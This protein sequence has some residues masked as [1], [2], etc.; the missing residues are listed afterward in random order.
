VIRF[1]LDTNICIYIIKKR[2]EQA[3]RKLR[4]LRVSE[5]GISTITLSELEYGVSKSSQPER[6]KMA[7]V[8]FLAPIEI[9]PYDEAA[10]GRYG[11]IRVGLEREGR[12]IGSLDTLIAAHAL[13]LGCTLVTN[14]EAEFGRIP[15]LNLENWAR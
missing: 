5:V 13:S 8:A 15:G 6:N 11:E 2:P 4:H 1:L 9:L 3:L 7:L 10:A 14:N 12:P